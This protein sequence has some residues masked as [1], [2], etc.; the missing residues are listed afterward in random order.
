MSMKL[1]GLAVAGMSIM[2]AG[3]Q[4]ALAQDA[5][6]ALI[7]GFKN[8]KA[9]VDVNVRYE[10][11]DD[12]NSDDKAKGLTVRTRLGYQTASMAGFRLLGEF[13]DTRP[14]FGVN[15][16]QPEQP[17]DSPYPTIADPSNTEVNRAFVSYS[18]FDDLLWLA[19]GRQRI[20]LDNWRWVG[21]VGWR[22]KEQTFDAGS[23]DLNFGS[24]WALSYDYITQVQT[25][26]A[27][28]TD[29]KDHLV[30]LSFAGWDI[31]Q[32]VAYAYLLNNEDTDNKSDS[33]G[34]R[35][36]GSVKPNN[37]SFLY[38]AEYARQSAKNAMSEKFNVNY[39]TLMLGLGF[40]PVTLK[41]GYEVLGSDGGDYGLQTDLATKHAF[42]GWADLFLTTPK[43]GLRDLYVD[44]GANWLGIKW[45]A[46]Y[47]NFSADEG[48]DRY[49]SE[50]DLLAVKKFNKHYTV[51]LKYA[52]FRVD[53]DVEDSLE[54]SLRDVSKFWV[55]FNFKY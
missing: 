19:G 43:N 10:Q 47:H 25:I 3:V 4:P 2:A 45:G 15:D 23:I 32:L 31:G 9:I 11:V 53:S 28:T 54:Y 35:F 14:L 21:N 36:N 13:T 39:Y 29:V 30:N 50:I 48:S 20:I 5:D 44:L 26:S 38:T 46:I 55:W 52:N 24:D 37:L 49:G 34:L 33:Y 7:R 27:T 22:Q 51:A 17:K 12:D 40:K 1:S 16:Y 8:G 42:N 41:L 6:D 18:A